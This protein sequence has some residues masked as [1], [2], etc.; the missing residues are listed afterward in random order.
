MFFELYFFSFYYLI[1]IFSRI[2]RKNSY[3]KK[4]TGNP[5]KRT[6]TPSIHKFM[7]SAV[8]WQKSFFFIVVVDEAAHCYVNLSKFFCDNT[9][10]YDI[11]FSNRYQTMHISH[12]N[13]SHYI[14]IHINTSEYAHQ[15]SHWHLINTI[16]IF[17]QFFFVARAHNT[18]QSVY[19]MAS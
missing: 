14:H 19:R 13:I 2:N 10:L 1:F 5:W 4:T 8:R 16:D 11:F 18:I 7:R 3:R 9:V 12:T 6:A 17:A 15:S